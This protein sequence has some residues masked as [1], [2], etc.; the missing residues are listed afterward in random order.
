[1]RQHCHYCGEPQ[2]SYVVFDSSKHKD[3]CIYSDKYN[4]IDLGLCSIC[5]IELTDCNWAYWI[6]SSKLCRN[7]AKE[8]N[9][10]RS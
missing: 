7:C 4:P 2:S 10:T 6:S 5:E 9:D 8:Q 1:M 3:W